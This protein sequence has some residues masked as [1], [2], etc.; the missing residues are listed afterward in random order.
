MRKLLVSAILLIAGMAGLNA[1]SYLND[2]LNPLSSNRYEGFRSSQRV[3]VSQFDYK[4]GFVLKTGKGGLIS[5][6]N[7]GFVVYDL[8]GAYSKLTFVMGP[9]NPNSATIRQNVIVTAKA[10]GRRIMDKVVRC[11]NAPEFVT[12]D[13]TGVKELRFDLPR[14]ET[15]MAF[16]EVR[17]WKPGQTV[18]APRDPQ[19]LTA[20]SKVKL[21][22]TLCPHYTRHS[23]Y[24]ATIRENPVP[25]SYCAPKNHKAM[26]INGKTFNSGLVFEASMQL[27][28]QDAWSYFWVEKKYD[29]LSFIL[30]PC[31][32]QSKNATGWLIVKADDRII[33]EK[34]I[35]QTDLAEQVVLDISGAESISFHSEFNGGDFLGGL[36]FGLADMYVW[37]KGASSL[38]LAGPV[39]L[40]KEKVSNLPDVCPLMSTIKPYSVRGVSQADN[41]LFTGESDY[42]T[43]SMGGEKFSEGLIL[44]T[45]NT[46]MEDK[47]DS[48]VAFDLA[49]EYDWVSFKAGCLTNHR[50]LGDD[51]IQVWADDNLVLETTIHATW[52]NQYFELPINKCR[53]LKFAK[54]GNGKSKQ[55]YF[56]VGDIAL[57]RGKPVANDLF[58]HE[59]PYCPEEADLIDLCKRPYF[60]YVGRYLSSLTNF[61]FND[62]FKNGSSQREYFQMKDGSKIY[63]GVMLETNIPLGIE[64]ISLTDM[65][66]M[67]VTGAGSSISSSHIGAVTGITAGAGMGGA[68][69]SLKL[70]DNSGR[71]S[72]VAAFN[73]YGEYETCTFTVANKSEYSDA[74]YGLLS[75]GRPA[76][77]V[78]LNVFADQRLVGEF[79]LDNKMAP[80][81][82]TVPIYKCTQLMFW[83][84]CGD[85]RSGQYVLY[86]MKVSKR[87]CGLPVPERYSP[88]Q[89][90]KGAGASGGVAGDLAA[91]GSGAAGSGTGSVAGDKAGSMAG[92]G[93]GSYSA[94]AAGDGSGG[95]NSSKAGFNDGI[96]GGQSRPRGRKQK[97][98]EV[99]ERVTWTSIGYSSSEAVNSFL[100][101]VDQI[102]KATCELPK[103]KNVPDYRLSQTWVEASDGQA[104]KYVTLVDAQ[105]NR[106]STTD[107]QNDILARISA[108][109]IIRTNTKMAYVG[110]PSASLGVASLDSFDSISRFSKQVKLGKTVLSQCDSDAQTFSDACQQ[111]LDAI[112]GLIRRAVD[113]DGFKSTATVMI[114]PQED[115][116]IL[117][118]VMQRLA[119]FNF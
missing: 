21:V 66:F 31:D 64:D 8:G 1:Q 26:N 45:G 72:S 105:G 48:Y 20:S 83:L 119:Y 60:H 35:S 9:Y 17:L 100:R 114:I 16:G 4:G 12:L 38:P 55:V 113:V 11:Y 85:T 15:D 30:G 49:G 109:K 95:K 37:P 91:D 77:P 68:L 53:I 42:Y 63:K 118:E 97:E 94:S 87:P 28:T 62:C 96:Y 52:P 81:T 71:Q 47:I 98:E 44:T 39:N 108:A 82:F 112:Q 58:R 76:P 34:L 78:K 27:D 2:I 23:G 36:L 33:Y 5:E 59:K 43:F 56:G 25:L 84:E 57:Y 24:V 116:D 22:E 3:T 18:Q 7:P 79:W 51:I 106:L 69:A 75:G 32:N 88:A 19:N 74:V 86:D 41:T 101:D 93:S 67:F 92:N 70:M 40:N 103:L 89:G 61:D 99:A 54:P 115:G 13:V 111:E 117:P 29:K 65:V 80:S 10:D 102:W 73:P 6:P 46:F 90:A 14:G 110:L 104:Y 107:I 50:V